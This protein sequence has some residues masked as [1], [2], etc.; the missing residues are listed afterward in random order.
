MSCR[1][2][3]ASTARQAPNI[4][5][6][7]C[8]PSYLRLQTQYLI[9]PSHAWDDG[10]NENGISPSTLIRGI[11]CQDRILR[12]VLVLDPRQ[13]IDPQVSDNRLSCRPVLLTGKLHLAILPD[14]DVLAE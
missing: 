14:S 8:F 12:K 10:L 3:S 2:S 11:S 4:I 9:R 13:L 1:H 6:I 5:S 7:S